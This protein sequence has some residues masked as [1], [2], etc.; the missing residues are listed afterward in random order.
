MPI[1]LPVAAF[2]LAAVLSV[3]GPAQAVPAWQAAWT[4]SLQS[5]PDLTDPPALYAKPEVAGR[6]V[7]QVIYPDL[8]GREARLRIS[9]RYGSRPL[10]IEHAV[11][12]RSNGATGLVPG[13]AAAVT[14]AGRATLT[15]AP[16]AEADSDVIAMD[17]V[18]GKPLAVS[19]AL[20]PHQTMQAWHRVANRINFISKAGD[21]AQTVAGTDLR[22]RTTHYAW[23]T[24]LSVPAA[25][26][27]SLVAI[28]DSITDGMRSTFGARHSWPEDLARLAAAEGL[29]PLAVLNAGISGNRLLSD[30]PC[31]GERLVG[32]FDHDAALPGVRAVILLIGI[33][34]IDFADTP[35]R[36]GLDCDAPHTKVTANDLIDGYKRVIEAAHRRGLRIFGGTLTPAALPPAR[37]ALRQTVN[38]W[39]RH[40]GGF[41]GVID[42]DAALRDPQHPTR[43]LPAYNSGD[44]I[45]PND[46][47]YAAMARAVPLT[48][49]RDILSHP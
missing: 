27:G 28:G 21:Y 36:R 42:F 6:T 43:L 29:P 22:G 44:G 16:G 15:L 38:Q 47:G 8:D 9:N 33:N 45:H 39:I 3:T 14:F 41:D 5:I 20:G 2:A 37:E 11:I 10:V 19:L 24:Q 7:R 46:A 12:A 32:R 13:T 25:G 40:G 1:R 30:S 23:V 18:R 26:P 35:P 49:L 48:K 4:T 34:D 31:Y 17:V